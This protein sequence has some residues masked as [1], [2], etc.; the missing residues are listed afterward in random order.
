M[1]RK[2]DVS[3]AFAVSTVQPQSPDEKLSIHASLNAGYGKSSDLPV[4][5]IPKEGTVDYRVMTL[6]FRYQL[7]EKD[8]FVVQLLNRRLGS[9]PRAGVLNDLTSQLAFWQHRS[10]GITTMVGRTPLPRG[11]L[12]EVRYI[13]TVLPFYRQP[14]E[15]SGDAF[16]AL[17]GVLVST[18]HELSKGFSVEG[19]EQ[20]G[21]RENRSVRATNTELTVRSSRAHD[22]S[23]AQ[24]YLDAPGGGL[25]GVFANKYERRTPTQTGF[26]NIVAYS[27]QIDRSWGTRLGEHIRRTQ[28]VFFTNAQLNTDIPSVRE[29]GAAINVFTAVGAALKFEHRWRKGYTYDAFVH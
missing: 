17:D 24:G 9:S 14:F 29:T 25:L 16:D 5:G 23:G 4:L 15:I 11:L 7:A 13:G 22:M 18:R 20:V 28:R 6:Q 1:C 2:P 8:T 26:R 21:A 10:N 27:G 19:H 3:A 12:N